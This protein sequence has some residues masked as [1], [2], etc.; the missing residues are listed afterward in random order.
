[1]IW[2]ASKARLKFIVNVVLNF[3]KDTIYAVAGDLVE[4]HKAGTDFLSKLCAVKARPADIAISTNGGYP[5]DQNTYQAVKGMTAAEATVKDGGVII[6][7]SASDDGTGG[8]HFYHQL[9][10]NENI[11]DTIELFLSRGRNET[12]PDQWQSQILLRILKKATVI[13][14]SNLPD[15]MVKSMHMLPSHNLADAIIL[16]KNILKKQD[17]TITAIPDGLAVMVVK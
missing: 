4:A 17:A 1:M 8:D 7:L 3:K 16:A 9:A 2:A 10:D 15:D 5:L 11:D 6:M 14:V 12:A 13:Y